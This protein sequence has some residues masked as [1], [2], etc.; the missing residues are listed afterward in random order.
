MELVIM[1]AGL[2]SRFGGLKQLEPIDDDGNFIIDY[3]IFDA[4]RCGFNKIIFIIKKENLE[5]FRETIGKRIESHIETE[6]VF[7]DNSNIPSIY[8]IP[9]DRVKPFGTGHALLCA[10]NA[11][12]SNFAIINADDFYGYDAFNALATFLKTSVSANHYCLIGY[13][14]DNTISGTGS[15]NRGVCKNNNDVLTDIIESKISSENNLLIAKPISLENVEYQISGDTLVSMNMFGFSQSVLDG[16]SAQ[17]DLFL[18]S[19]KN[20][21]SKCE[22]FL[23]TVISNMIKHKEASV[24]LIKT[25]AK[26]YGITYREDKEKIIKAIS[27]MKKAK[28][29]PLNLWQV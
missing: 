29:Y 11:V 1:A 14:V 27:E 23:P 12:S 21:L 3:S 6:Y 10:K 24:S 4:I 15:V 20:D 9:Q 7:Q 28:I 19:N 5:I 18:E 2:G 16:L 26:W 13:R 8:N 22:F 25:S 17:F